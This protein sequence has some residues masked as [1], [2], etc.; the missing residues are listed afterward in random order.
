M[1][2]ERITKKDFDL[3]N[4]TSSSEGLVLRS[5]LK[6]NRLNAHFSPASIFSQKEN[7]SF[8][9]VLQES[10]SADNVVVAKTLDTRSVS[11]LIPLPSFVAS[12][13]EKQTAPNIDNF[14][15]EL[16]TKAQHAGAR[17]GLDPKMLIAQAALETGWGKSIIKD[18]QG[19][20][21]NNLFNIKATKHNDASS[22]NVKTTEYAAGIPLQIKASFKTYASLAE[23]FDDYVVFIKNNHRYQHAVAQ[24]DNAAQYIEELNKAGYATDPQYSS[25]ILAIYHSDA[26]DSA[27][28]KVS[29]IAV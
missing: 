27:I 19:V 1:S 25:K 10:K 5:L 20:S 7:V 4:V 14:V 17:I 26:L 3:P 21:S 29:T 9:E 24:A 18:A 16:W 12:H 8:Q 28:K 22:V 13:V 11:T 23:S 6:T 15:Q 2:I